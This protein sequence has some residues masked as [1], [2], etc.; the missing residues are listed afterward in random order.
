MC[1]NKK[2]EMV[3]SYS[4]QILVW[5]E[6]HDLLVLLGASKAKKEGAELSF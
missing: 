2:A 5:K 1:S 6:Q 3:Q 4:P